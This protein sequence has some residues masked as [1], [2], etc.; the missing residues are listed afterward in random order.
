[1]CPE[2]LLGIQASWNMG[3]AS[4]AV[5]AKSVCD[6]KIFIFFFWLI[7]ICNINSHLRLENFSTKI[8]RFS[9][10][11]NKPIYR[12]LK[13]AKKDLLTFSKIFNSQNVYYTT[14]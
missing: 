2:V 7:G 5:G 12:K 1:M 14:E 9:Q 11:L 8:N 6:I 10:A 13:R 4:K 3:H